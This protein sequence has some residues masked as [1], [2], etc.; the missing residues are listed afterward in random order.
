MSKPE[1]AETEPVLDLVV[2]DEPGDGVEPKRDPAEVERFLRAEGVVD[3]FE[4]ALNYLVKYQQVL[5]TL[6]SPDP[7]REPV[8]KLLRRYKFVP[9]DAS[10]NYAIYYGAREISDHTDSI[11]G[12]AV[13]LTTEEIEEAQ[14]RLNRA[15]GPG[16][17]EDDGDHLFESGEHDG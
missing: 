3:D 16:T 17:V 12:E 6:G 4:L 10:T 8:N 14:A 5:H 1:I 2:T 15:L 7:Q 9:H 11:P 13:P